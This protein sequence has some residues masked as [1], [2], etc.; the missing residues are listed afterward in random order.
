MLDIQLFP[1]VS[2]LPTI[3]KHSLL[4]AVTI[5]Q[6]PLH[7]NIKRFYFQVY[8]SW[9]LKPEIGGSTCGIKNCSPQVTLKNSPSLSFSS[10]SRFWQHKSWFRTPH[11]YKGKAVPLQA[12]SGPDGSRK[13]R[14]PHFMKTA[15]DGGKVVSRMHRPPFPPRKYTW[16]SFLLEAESTPGS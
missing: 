15:Q 2:A 6:I 5:K 1:T 3:I 11:I 4:P 16:Y 9:F 14:F 7:T 10:L 12:W 8:W 13:L